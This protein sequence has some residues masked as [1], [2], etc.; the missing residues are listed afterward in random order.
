MPLKSKDRKLVHFK[1]YQGVTKESKD[2]VKNTVIDFYK[3]VGCRPQFINGYTFNIV[4]EYKDV[5]VTSPFTRRLKKFSELYSE[6]LGATVPPELNKGKKEV[7]IQLKERKF[8]RKIWKN[9]VEKKYIECGIL[10]EIGHNFDNFYGQELEEIKIN[11]VIYFK[12]KNLSDSIE[13]RE[14]MKK[15]LE[16]IKVS[17][18]G[19]IQQQIDVEKTNDISFH[20]ND[21]SDY[22]RSELFAQLFA[23]A[24]GKDDGK[25]RHSVALYYNSYVL[26]KNYI[27]QYIGLTFN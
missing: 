23:Y 5:G 1:Y 16:T 18:S 6:T 3:K 19:R 17:K 8:P 10:H 15:D 2:T 13:F 21:F 24:F 12:K 7:V 25:R 11:N 14:A 22:S 9:N 4:N 20:S 27:K 26:V